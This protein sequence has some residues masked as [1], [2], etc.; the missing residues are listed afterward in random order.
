MPTTKQII[1]YTAAASVAGTGI[2]LGAVALKGCGKEPI[3]NQVYNIDA[4]G[5]NRYF[6]TPGKKLDFL[7]G[8]LTKGPTIPYANGKETDILII[9]REQAIKDNIL[10][11]NF[12]GAGVT[13]NGRRSV[14]NTTLTPAEKKKFFEIMGANPEDDHII[15][16]GM[17]A[18]MSGE[19]LMIRD[20]YR[21]KVSGLSESDLDAIDKNIYEGKNNI[22]SIKDWRKSGH[23]WEGRPP[24][25]GEKRG[26]FY[27]IEA[28][29]RFVN[30]SWRNYDDIEDKRSEKGNSN[31]TFFDDRTEF[32]DKTRSIQ[33]LHSIGISST[34]PPTMVS[35][36]R[37]NGKSY[38]E[39][40]MKPPFNF[41]KTYRPRN[42]LPGGGRRR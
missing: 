5:V 9:G 19:K 8:L 11:N 12:D 29:S 37:R 24:V 31:I 27:Q 39:I 32:N 38:T 23:G 16:N 42:N 40:R 7:A 34:T 1:G 20:I 25:I 3:M 28:N 18:Y 15:C 13:F 21:I 22:L 10:Y 33:E 36:R 14:F 17:E 6:E 30:F 35:Y 26:S 41:N 2:I 4:N